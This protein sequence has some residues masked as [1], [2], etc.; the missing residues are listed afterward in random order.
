MSINKKQSLLTGKYLVKNPFLFGYLWLTDAFFSL[1]IRKKKENKTIDSP[2][3]ILV[4]NI[5]HFGDVI[6]ATSVLPVIKKAF[7]AME[8]GFFY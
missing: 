3:K 1:F 6:I 5:A 4:S 8:I 2:K 7:P